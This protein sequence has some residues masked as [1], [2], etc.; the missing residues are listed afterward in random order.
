MRRLC[1]GYFCESN[2]WVCKDNNGWIPRHDLY[3]AGCL[4]IV[5]RF[6]Q[7]RPLDCSW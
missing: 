1:Y 2:G 6:E 7:R 4:V 5:F 3:T